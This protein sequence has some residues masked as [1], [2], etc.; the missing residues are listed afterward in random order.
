[1]ALQS[2]M[3]GKTW[4]QEREAA[5]PTAAALREQR[6]ISAGAQLAL[7]FLFSPGHVMVQ[8]TLQRGFPTAVKLLYKRPHGYRQMVAS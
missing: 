1:M 7:M 6:E 5:G 4:W 8:P 2:I 3:A